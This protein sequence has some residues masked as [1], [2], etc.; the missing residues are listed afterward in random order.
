MKKPK[1]FTSVV[2]ML[3]WDCHEYS[4]EIGRLKAE[5]AELKERVA[6]LSQADSYLANANLTSET[7]RAIQ[8]EKENEQLRKA[9]DNLDD[10]IQTYFELLP[11]LLNEMRAKAFLKGRKASREWQ[12][13]KGVQS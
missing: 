12:K 3:T 9:G 1:T 13:A 10:A 8:M 7:E 6:F 11:T 2:E 5:N 4:L